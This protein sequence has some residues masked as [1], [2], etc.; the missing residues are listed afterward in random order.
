MN[1][2][3]LGA[4]LDRRLSFW[5]NPE[6]KP[7]Q[8]KATE[9]GETQVVTVDFAPIGGKAAVHVEYRL[10]GDG[11][12]LVTETMD[13]ELEGL[14]QLPRFGLRFAMNG[15]FE[16]VDFFGL[17]PWENYADRNSATL[18]GRYQQKVAD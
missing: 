6:L 4:R 1:E 9:E 7:S 3:D 15:R 11:S 8:V 12:I 13:G 14:P 5:R 16:E 2:N 18:L 10:S 17:G